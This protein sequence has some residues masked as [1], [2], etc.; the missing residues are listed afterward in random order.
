MNEFNNSLGRTNTAKFMSSNKTIIPGMEDVYTEQ[1]NFGKQNAKVQDGTYVPNPFGTVPTTPNMNNQK[2]IEVFCI[3][4][5][6]Q[7]QASF[8]L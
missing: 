5:Q 6:N 8:G 4:F 1:P 3:Q 2:P 7:L